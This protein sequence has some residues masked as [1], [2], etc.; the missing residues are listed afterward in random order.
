MSYHVGEK[1]QSGQPC[2]ICGEHELEIV[3]TRGRGGQHLTTGICTGCGLV[4]SYPIPTKEELDHYYSQ[5]YR[6]DYKGVFTPQRKHILRYSRAALE[7]LARLGQFAPKGLR[8]LDVGSGSGEFVYL[9]S[10]AGFK[11]EGLEPHTGYS[12]YTRSTFGV[13]ITTAVLEQAEIGAETIDVITLHHV[14][15]HLQFPLTSLSILNRW[16]KP[17]G[18]IMV[19]VPDIETTHHSPTNRYHYAHIYNFNHDTLKAIL[20]KAGFEVIDHPDYRGTVLCARKVGAPDPAKN[21]AMPE[22]YQRL[23]TL[24]AKEHA[25]VAYKRKKPLFRLLRKC[26]RYPSEIVVAALL[27]HPRRIAD[28]VFRRYERAAG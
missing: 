27:G 22:N 9:A 8:L 15:E 23:K 24:L 28:Y 2:K 11:A 18:L 25:A 4:H 13:P 12:D 10:R 20:S 19:D 6:N 1:L 14:L 3:A 7:R 26:W 17:G 21:I 5:N 16:L